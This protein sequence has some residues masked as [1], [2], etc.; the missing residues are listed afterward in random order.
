MKSI[1]KVSV[2]IG[3]L[4]TLSSNTLKAQAVSAAANTAKAFVSLEAALKNPIKVYRLDLSNQ[5]FKSLPDSIWSKF[6]NLEYLSLKNDHLREIPKGIGNLKNLRVLDLSGNDFKVLPQSFSRLSNLS[7]I[8]L[9]DEKRMNYSKTFDVIK[10]LP[11]LRVLHL[12]NDYLKKIPK[13]LMNLQQIESLYLN[14]NLLNTFPKELKDLRNLKYL[15][16]HDNKFKFKNHELQNFGE[17]IKIR[18]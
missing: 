10:N 15:D 11:N 3:M 8:Y 14:N 9:N 12:E 16:L 18:F 13:S 7:E 5:Q 17:G 6:E 2:L 1:I 4:F